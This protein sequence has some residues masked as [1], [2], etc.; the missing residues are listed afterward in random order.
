M[1]QK[2]FIEL[3][4][5]MLHDINI[6]ESEI[7]IDPLQEVEEEEEVSTVLCDSPQSD[8]YTRFSV[9]MNSVNILHNTMVVYCLS[10]IF[11][12]NRLVSW[13]LRMTFDD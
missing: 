1:W 12:I 7:L 11:H 4:F 9:V 13:L 5:S 8:P 10:V 2:Y 3:F 6:E